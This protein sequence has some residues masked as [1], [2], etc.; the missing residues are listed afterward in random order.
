MKSKGALGRIEFRVRNPSDQRK[1]SN[2]PKGQTSPEPPSAMLRDRPRRDE[3]SYALCIVAESSN[4]I[5]CSKVIQAPT[6]D[7]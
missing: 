3:E 1:A 6:S 7:T 2:P 5:L 4:P